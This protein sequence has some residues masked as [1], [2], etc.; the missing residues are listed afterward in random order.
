MIRI[1]AKLEKRKAW[2]RVW[3]KGAWRK[4]HERLIKQFKA[5]IVFDRGK[6]LM[7]EASIILI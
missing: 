4:F 2:K 3:E 1:E 7:A 6:I 5:E